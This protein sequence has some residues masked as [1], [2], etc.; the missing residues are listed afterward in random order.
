MKTNRHI[1]RSLL[2]VT[3]IF[4]TIIQHEDEKRGA[5]TI[6]LRP[7]F[8]CVGEIDHER[9]GIFFRQRL[10]NPVLQSSEPFRDAEQLLI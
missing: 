6:E 10:E 2:I 3:S 9:G 4:S 8:D 5:N 1:D 7:G